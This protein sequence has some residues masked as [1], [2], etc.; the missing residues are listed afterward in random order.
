VRPALGPQ[1]ASAT[2]RCARPCLSVK[3]VPIETTTRFPVGKILLCITCRSVWCRH[4]VVQMRIADGV[5][6][7]PAVVS[8]RGRVSW[9][10]RNSHRPTSSGW[11][12]PSASVLLFCPHGPRLAN[13]RRPVIGAAFDPGT[14]QARSCRWRGRG[15]SVRDCRSRRPSPLAALASR[16]VFGAA[17]RQRLGWLD[18][19]HAPCYGVGDAVP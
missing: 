12:A 11:R 3:Q 16:N 14:V 2:V 9:I 10:N 4:K 15:D 1:H 5:T 13:F 8:S 19:D 6:K 17:F 18:L 7:R